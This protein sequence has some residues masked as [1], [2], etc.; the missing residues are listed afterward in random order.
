MSGFSG[1]TEE[2]SKV[3]FLRKFNVP[4]WALAE[5][6]GRN[7]MYWYRQENTL[8]RFSL[9]G[10]TINKKEFLPDNISAD[11]KHTKILGK[12]ACIATTVADDCILGCELVEDAG[13]HSLEKGYGV[14]KKEAKDIDINYSPKT[15]NLDGWNATNSTWKKIFPKIAI[16]SC[17]LHVYI[18]L[19][20][21]SKIKFKEFF[22]DTA[23]KL[24]DCYNSST[25]IEFTQK[26][27]EFAK[28]SNSNSNLLP[29]FIIDKIK[30]LRK[31]YRKF[32]IAFD[33]QNAHRTSNMIDRLM[34]KMNRRLF[35]MQYF[36]G[37]YKNGK[38]NI[39]SWALIQ[40]F[41]PSNPWTVKKYSGLK[42]PAERLNKI[43]YSNNWLE[44]LLISSSLSRKYYTEIDNP[45]K[46][47]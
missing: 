24:W 38:L 11:E 3:L 6:F 29:D 26:I 8:G 15:V 40:N 23:D 30:K 36:Q 31:E 45:P 37:K 39:R 5:I 27:R 13:S 46:P 22:H 33:Y 44:N 16:I 9:V 12:K 42:S 32:S 41:A 10:T 14:F 21:R 34:Q 47:L 1:Y 20:D 4:F 19:R 43:S 7:A 25:K 18:K 2:S 35:A 17:F 28:W